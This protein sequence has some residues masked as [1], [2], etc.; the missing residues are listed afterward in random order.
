MSEVIYA[1]KM[2][3]FLGAIVCMWGYNIICLTGQLV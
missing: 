3:C 1:I 2:G